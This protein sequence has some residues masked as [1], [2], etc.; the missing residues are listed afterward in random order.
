[1]SGGGGDNG[2]IGMLPV[3]AALAATVMTDGAAAPLLGEALG[4]EAG[5]VGATMLG[6]SVIG[7]GVGGASA[8][9]TGRDVGQGILTGGA[10]GAITSG[11]GSMMDGSFA[12][13]L[14]TDAANGIG[15]GASTTQIGGQ[16]FNQ[17]L[18]DASSQAADSAGYP[19]ADNQFRVSPLSRTYDVVGPNGQ[20]T[21]TGADTGVP[22]QVGQSY[23]PGGKEYAPLSPSGRYAS[24][25]F[26]EANGTTRPMVAG[27]RL[28]PNMTRA[29]ADFPTVTSGG[30]SGLANTPAAQT[31]AQL[32]N[33]PN[34]TASPDVG[35]KNAPVVKTD[36]KDTGIFG[37]GITSKQ[38]LVGLGGLALWNAIQNENK[39][40]GVPTTQ[41]SVPSNLNY[42]LQNHTPMNLTRSYAD[43][44]TVNLNTS[45]IKQQINGISTGGNDMFPQPG[46]HS[47]QYANPIS[48]PVPGN[49]LSAPTDTEV[50]PYTGQQRMAAGGI[51]Q[52]T[53][54]SYAAGGNPRLLKGPGD[55][56]SD[57]IPATIGSKQPARLADGEF[58]VPA[59]VVSH[60][61][62]GS[63]DAGA[64]KLHSMMDNVRKARTGKKAQGKQI[65]ADKYMPKFAEGGQVP[66]MQGITSALQNQNTVSN[67]F[68]TNLGRTADP[69]GGA[70]WNNQLNTG[71]VT[72]S[73]VNQYIGNS[74]EAMTPKVDPIAAASQAAQGANQGLQ[75]QNTVSNAYAT[76][77]GR[78]ADPLGNS[79]WNNQLNTG[80]QNAAGVNTM[81]ANSPEAQANTAKGIAAANVGPVNAANQ[82]EDYRNSMLQQYNP[83][84]AF[85]QQQY[86]TSLGRSSDAT[87]QKY[88]A[89]QINSGAMTPDQV[90]AALANS[91]EAGI[92]QNVQTAN[93][94]AQKAA[95]AAAQKAADAAA[96]KKQ[97]D[98]VASPEY[99]TWL[100]APLTEQNF[101]AAQYLK[102]NPDAGN[103]A[104]WQSTPW[105]HYQ[106][107]MA[108]GDIR[109]ATKLPYQPT[110]A[111]TTASTDT[112][113][114]NTQS[115]QDQFNT[116]MKNYQQNQ[117][118]QQP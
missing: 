31:Q 10:T 2:V 81:L 38:A 114:T 60:L 116:F 39:K 106:E 41:A 70:Y 62:N 65:K 47:N 21:P 68:A 53:L 27:D 46:L 14:S 35:A 56:M 94:A 91:K 109:K 97:A 40:Y 82:M 49:V 28:S 3:A 99:Q 111:A 25:D 98:L 22:V 9:L 18:Y 15:P 76:N 42:S 33:N 17:N 115:L 93:T 1:M 86:N 71:A 108:N 92:Y 7:A 107:A 32:Q 34:T 30:P 43:G 84:N 113:S 51:A 104:I 50:D 54:G 59:D 101:D 44:G 8:A 85:V 5:T 12:S 13:G 67:A 78:T 24:A 89:N 58:V 112:A 88:W 80:A 6:S 73:Q 103:P 105:K 52:T 57:N 55:G 87:G 45:P 72:P 37:S 26:L 66:D 63:T 4:A 36:L 20:F 95:D 61:G 19:G 29:G 69:S 11:V 90:A 83:T 79:Y 75:N 102:D 118:S 48:T 100:N 117:Q 110:A 77:L 64:Q 74:T 16:E 23:T 96:Q